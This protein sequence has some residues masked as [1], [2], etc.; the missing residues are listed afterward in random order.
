MKKRKK[1]A[2][3]I[4]VIL[5]LSPLLFWGYRHFVQFQ[6]VFDQMYYSRVTRGWSS[7]RDT[8]RYEQLNERSMVRQ[9]TIFSAR[10]VYEELQFSSGAF[11]SGYRNEYLESGQSIVFSFQYYL[12][13][14]IDRDRVLGINFTFNWRFP[15]EDFYLVLN[16]HYELETRTLTKHPVTLSDRT[17]NYKTTDET[18]INDFLAQQDITREE[19]DELHYSFFYDQ[20]LGD[21]F[22][23]NRWHTRFSRNNLGRF[24]FIDETE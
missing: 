5:L 22:A 3:L 6:N 20:I 19:I 23:A 15:E 24:T 13:P 18:T 14:V 12:F 9:R 16:Y 17:R 21:W 7:P 11:F 8:F 2:H 1:K 4:I 10:Y